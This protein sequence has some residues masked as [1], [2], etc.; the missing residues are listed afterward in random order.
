MK[1]LLALLA[2]AAS[3]AGCVTDTSG[4][5]VEKGRLV[6]HN[7]RFASHLEMQYQLK[8]ET[9][10]NFVHVQAFLQNAD[11]KDFSFQY[12]FEWK[13]ADGMMLRETNPT[14]KVATIHGRDTLALEG[15]SESP[16]AADFRLVVKPLQH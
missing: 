8:R 1:K 11:S 2:V 10:S 5:V 6:V 16:H 3:F 15:V 4:I 7:Q 12:R 13:D 14:W 9:P